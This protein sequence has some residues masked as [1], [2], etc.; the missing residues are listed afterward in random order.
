MT[1][2]LFQQI[3]RER[4]LA[5]ATGL[6]VECHQPAAEH[7]YTDA[8]RREFRIT[9]LC[10]ECFDSICDDFESEGTDGRDTDGNPAS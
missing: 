10:E 5:V 2:N 1:T 7:C 4:A 6:C 9:G 3:L 8:G